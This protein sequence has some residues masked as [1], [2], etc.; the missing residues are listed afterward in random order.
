MEN[1]TNNQYDNDSGN[2]EVD[3][4]L[5]K[6]KKILKAVKLNPNISLKSIFQIGKKQH[7]TYLNAIK[8]L[9]EKN[10]KNA[11]HWCK[12]FLKTY[13][14][15]YSMRCILAY[16]YTCLNNYE[17][18]HL[19]LNEAIKLKEKKPTA[20]YIRGKIQFKQGNYNDAVKDLTTSIY[21][22]ANINNLYTILGISYYNNNNDEYALKTF[23]IM[24]KNDPNNYLCLKYCAYIYEKQ[25]KFSDTL[26]KLKNLLSINEKDS[27]ILCYHGEILSKMKKYDNAVLDLDRLFELNDDISFAYLLQKYSDFW[28][29]MCKSYIINYYTQLGITNN[30]DLYMYR[31]RGV[32][33]MSNLN[34][35]CQFQKN[36]LN[37]CTLSLEDNYLSSPQLS[38]TDIFLLFPENDCYDIIWKI[39]IK[40]MISSDC[41]I[42]FIV[43]ES[44]INTKMDYILKYKDILNLEG[45]GWISYVP[46]HSINLKIYL[47][48]QLSIET[49]KDSIDMQIEYVRITKDYHKER[50]Y[51]PKMDHLLPFY[52]NNIPETFKDKYFLRKETEN[53]LELKDII[54]NL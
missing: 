53:L 14:E 43:E 18:A 22:N 5:T 2:S 4:M 34:Y 8:G 26:K 54:N 15:S 38:I 32:Y 44:T 40:K 49:N 13:P 30:F 29:Y 11:E 45:I 37:R 46:F 3:L 35:N 20:W 21:Y 48:I 51:F 19:Y 9:K 31:A 28:L 33:F 50:I 39:N 23:N 12:E 7:P 27:L 17:Q 6:K 41:F 10:Y 52:A 25:G 47:P 36:N 1:S 16:T 42:R 24:L